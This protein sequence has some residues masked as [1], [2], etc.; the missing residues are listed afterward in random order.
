M[1][2][3]KD[4]NL[5]NEGSKGSQSDHAGGESAPL[6]GEISPLPPRPP[7]NDPKALFEWTKVRVMNTL[8]PPGLP[9]EVQLLN[10]ENIAIPLNYLMVG[11]Y[12]GITSAVLNV[13]PL[14]IGATEAQQ[15]TI[16]I[17]RSLPASFKIVFGFI[18]DGYPIFGKRRKYYLVIGWGIAMVTSLILAWMSR[19]SVAWLSLLVGLN[20]TGFWWADVVGDSL[21]AEKAKL[22]PLESRGQLQTFCYACRFFMVMVTTTISTVWEETFTFSVSFFLSFL[23]PLLFNMPAIYYLIDPQVPVEPIKKQLMDMWETICL[24]AVWQPMG[25]VY[26]YNLLQI[27]NAAWQ[28]YLYTALNFTTK[29][30]NSFLIEAQILTF[31]GIMFYKWFLI[32]TSWRM[33]YVITTLLFA[34]I[35][36]L[37][38]LLIFGVNRQSG[39]GDYPFAM[40]QDVFAEFIAG[41]QFLPTTIMMVH[42]CPKGSEGAA[43][44]M[45][46]TISNAAGNL[47][48]TFSTLLL[49]IWNVCPALFM[50]DPPVIDGLWRLNLLTTVIATSAVLLVPLLP[51]GKDDLNNVDFMHKNRIGGG[52]FLFILVFSLLWSIIQAI[53]SSTTPNWMNVGVTCDE[54][55]GGA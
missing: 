27:P 6:K 12:Q 44:A 55:G 46:T 16:R 8:Y 53:L 29:Q 51:K 48:S 11:L 40:G 2:G 25:F 5:I 32:K 39:L 41:I 19:P 26:F 9:D 42:L 45:F 36:V 1:D 13:Y 20:S 35:S 34:G 14:E 43:Y 31:L 47:A 50:E 24:R 33:I 3:D 7:L 28:Q 30:L 15:T 52:I 38:F 17:L 54:G 49:P 4:K 10:K 23:F 18:S 37:Q 21:V 22:E